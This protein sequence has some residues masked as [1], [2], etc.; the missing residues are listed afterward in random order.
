MFRRPSV[1]LGRCKL[2]PVFSEDVMPLPNAIHAP[3]LHL[4]R[5]YVSLACGPCPCCTYRVLHWCY[6][7]YAIHLAAD[8][9]DDKWALNGEWRRA[10]VMALDY[11]RD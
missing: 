2:Y 9:W 7:G 4:P 3:C 11:I 6:H 8:D 5:R 1:T 10:E